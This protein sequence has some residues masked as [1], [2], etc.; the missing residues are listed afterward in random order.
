MVSSLSIIW[1]STPITFPSSPP[2]APSIG[3]TFCSSRTRSMDRGRSM[4]QLL[5]LSR[6]GRWEA[7]FMIRV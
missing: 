4:L 1:L 7:R 3:G 6:V 2:I 5:F